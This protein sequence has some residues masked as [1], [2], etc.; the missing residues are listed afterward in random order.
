MHAV[1]LYRSSL[2]VPLPVQPSE[3]TSRKDL[4]VSRLQAR[5]IVTPTVSVQPRTTLDA[6]KGIKHLLNIIFLNE[7]ADQ[8]LETLIK[9][10]FCAPFDAVETSS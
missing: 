7:S 6:D 3:I 9:L 4:Q 2:S 5:Y 8:V 10:G 1:S